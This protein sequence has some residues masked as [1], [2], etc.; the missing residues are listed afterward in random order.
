MGESEIFARAEEC[1]FVGNLYG[2]INYLRTQRPP[3]CEVK[4]LVEGYRESEL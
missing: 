1:T 2:F 4:L 3:F